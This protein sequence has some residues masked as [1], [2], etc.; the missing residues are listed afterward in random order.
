[1]T[2]IKFS[3]FDQFSLPIGSVVVPCPAFWS[4][5]GFKTNPNWARVE[6]S[7]NGILPGY[8]AMDDTVCS[9]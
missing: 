6:I 9:P 4:W 5:I 8:V 3:F 1:V 7:G 2:K